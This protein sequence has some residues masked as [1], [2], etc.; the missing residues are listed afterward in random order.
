M[1]QYSMVNH[2]HPV[3]V[4]GNMNPK[5][6]V[7]GPRLCA[8]RL[9]LTV[10][11]RHWMR[12]L[13]QE[14][15]NETNTDDKSA[16][17]KY[18]MIDE[19]PPFDITISMGNEH[20]HVARMAIYGVT[21]VGETGALSIN[22]AY[23]EEQFEFMANYIDYLDNKSTV[24]SVVQNNSTANI[25]NRPDSDTS[26]SDTSKAPADSKSH[27]KP[28]T[29]PTTS[30][31]V[32]DLAEEFAKD[33]LLR[34]T[35]DYSSDPYTYPLRDA[36]PA[37]T[38]EQL[39]ENIR[40]L[41]TKY[42]NL[43]RTT[44]ENIIN[45]DNPDIVKMAKDLTTAWRAYVDEWRSW[46]GKQYTDYVNEGKEPPTS[47]Y[48]LDDNCTKDDRNTDMVNDFLRKKRNLPESTE[49]KEDK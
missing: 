19:L 24:Q 46:K 23:T 47:I 22:D 12:K 33:Y 8:G 26:K 30:Q 40:Q 38:L 37:T 48:V 35:I 18:Y 21:I 28:P 11:D 6:F 31:P 1:I 15:R 27:P 20:G 13:M 25:P 16:T 49:V 39:P 7:F 44:A 29:P 5:A 34:E 42:N 43:I 10:F 41:R 17:E 32:S 14:Y 4:I 45:E 36:N 2:K 3:R 9:Y